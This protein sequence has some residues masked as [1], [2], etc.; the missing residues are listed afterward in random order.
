MM[1]RFLL[2]CLLWCAQAWALYNGNPSFPMMPDG[3]VFAKDA[4]VT[5]KTGYEFDDVF[6]QQMHVSKPQNDQKRGVQEF[7]T[8]G[9]FGA[10][11]LVISDRV[12]IYSMLGTMSAKISQKPYDGIKIHY[13]ANPH[14]AWSIGGRTILAYWGNTQLGMNAGYLRYQPHLNQI[15]VNGS[16][17]SSSGAELQYWE[18]QVGA[19]VSHRI[20]MLVPYVGGYYAQSEADFLYLNSLKSIIPGRHFLLKSS[21]NPGVAVG[22]GFAPNRGFTVNVEGRFI[23]QTALSASAEIKF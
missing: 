4:Y 19:G 13:K 21:K 8:L 2:L 9:N 3:G 11:K 12:E 16:T 15:K 10:I 5:L 7:K 22:C 14:F 1:N 6:K 20:G 18:W 17:Y 23:N